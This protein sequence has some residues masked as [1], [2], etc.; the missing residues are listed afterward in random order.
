VDPDAIEDDDDGL[1]S[2][3]E[4]AARNAQLNAEE[5]EFNRWTKQV[6]KGG[7]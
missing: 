3:F 5:E 6:N 7:V 1:Q 4:Q 2:K